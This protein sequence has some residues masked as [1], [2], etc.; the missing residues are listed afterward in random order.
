MQDPGRLRGVLRVRVVPER[1]EERA[2]PRARAIRSAEL[3]DEPGG[4]VPRGGR[5]DDVGR[6]WVIVQRVVATREQQAVRSCAIVLRPV[7]GRVGFIPDLDV[8]DEGNVSHDAAQERAVLV[9]S[10]RCGGGVSRDVVDRED[11]AVV[12]LDIRAIRRR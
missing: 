9:A 6:A 1:V 8:V 10:G 3:E 7:G 12:Q 4:I 11:D 5:A 2:E